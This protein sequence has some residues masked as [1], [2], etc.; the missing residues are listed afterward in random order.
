MPLSYTKSKVYS[1]E[2]VVDN[3]YLMEVEI[4]AKVKA[5][6][7]YMLRG[8][9]CEPILPRPI[10]IHDY[11]DGKISFL[12]IVCGV[13]TEH[14]KN[15]K[16]DDRIELLGPLGNGFPLDKLTGNVA[17]VAGG[18][19]TAPMLHTMKEMDAK[20]IDLYCGFRDKSYGIDKMKEYADEVFIATESGDEGHKGYVIDLL[21]PKKYDVVITCGPEIMMKKVADMCNEADV[22][23]YVSM[24]SHMACGVGACLVCT[25]KTKN[26]NKRACKEGPV[27]SSRDVIF[28]E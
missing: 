6:Q 23:C 17:V 27:F 5:G 8:W 14:L 21:D 9:G 16:K 1:N 28:G 15:L 19:G 22:E 13:G 20:K 26:G 10:S 24:E 3:V 11:K 2:H 25:C 18:I 7:F 12:Y 4:D